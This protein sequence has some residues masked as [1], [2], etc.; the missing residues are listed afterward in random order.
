MDN[1][2]FK[3]LLK[4]SL[5]NG[6][7]TLFEEEETLEPITSDD[8][9]ETNSESDGEQQDDDKPSQ[10]KSFIELIN[11]AAE[12]IERISKASRLKTEDYAMLAALYYLGR[13]HRTSDDSVDTENLN[14]VFKNNTSFNKI[15]FNLLS[16]EQKK[17]KNIICVF[18]KVLDWLKKE[19]MYQNPEMYY[20]SLAQSGGYD[21]IGEVVKYAYYILNKNS[22]SIKGKNLNLLAT[23][24]ARSIKVGVENLS[25]CADGM[26]ISADSDDEFG[27]DD[28]TEEVEISDLA[29]PREA[30]T[31]RDF[32]TEIMKI[33]ELSP[34]AVDIIQAISFDLQSSLG[35][36]RK[37][38]LGL[39][40]QS[41]DIQVVLQKIPNIKK[42][43][44]K[45]KIGSGEGAV[46]LAYIVI[47]RFLS[48]NN[49]KINDKDKIDISVFQASNR[50]DQISL[51]QKI[52]SGDANLEEQRYDMLLKRFNIK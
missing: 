30:Q 18:A 17:K 15:I 8:S 33:K 25:D 1:K 24:A 38:R 46:Q 10:K 13:Y 48:R 41:E 34:Y 12:E 6:A 27:D 31:I 50:K 51:I 28:D 9:D 49:L 2:H 7:A 42:V 32:G 47:G 26:D 43:L 16:A 22:Y 21:G 4:E 3:K 36:R 14:R 5:K 20:E 52:S 39:K 29:T 11:K 23:M 44:N 35:N 37:E 45:I 40:E 19:P